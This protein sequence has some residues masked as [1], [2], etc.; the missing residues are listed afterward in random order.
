MSAPRILIR[1][2]TPG[3]AAIITDFNLAMA[4]ETEQRALDRDTL[5]A[6]VR[7]A[8]TEDALGEYWLAQVGEK[9]AGQMMVTYEWSDWRNCLIW[10][11]QSVYV[12]PEF[13]GAGV[14]RALHE[15]VENRAR[16]SP[17]VG[18]L[19]LYVDHDNS[20]AQAVYEKLGMRK[21]NYDLYETD[22]SANVARTPAPAPPS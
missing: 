9:I 8:L 20:R 2:A 1:A 13:R 17:G 15:F 19:R 12:P 22:W 10:W 11:I 21:T 6:G 18:G 7:A 3:D 5:A 14:Y 16:S 4:R